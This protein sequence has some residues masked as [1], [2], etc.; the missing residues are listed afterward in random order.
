MGKRQGVFFFLERLAAMLAVLLLCAASA[1]SQESFPAKTVRVIVPWPPS[2]PPDMMSRLAAQ[3]LIERWGKP[4]IVENRPGATG[5]IG[6]DVV[7]KSAPDGH[8][9]LLTLNQPMVI[10][11]A[12]LRTPYDPVR[13]LLPIAMVGEGTNVLAVTPSLGVESVAELVA[14]AKAKPGALTFSSSGPGS[15]GHLCGELLKQLTGVDIVHV[16]YQGAA[17][18]TTAVITGEVSFG[19]MPVQ[20]VVPLV[21]AGKVKGLGVTSTRVSRFIPD[22]KPVS[23]QGL[24]GLVSVTWFAVYAPPKTPGPV[25]KVLRDG[26]RSAFEDPGIAQKLLAAGIEPRWEEAEQVTAVIESELAMW[27]RIVK[28]ARISKE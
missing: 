17:Q 3:K 22:L 19:F 21:K 14:A 12:L 28:A 4:V 7:A 26:M 16:P 2:G 20:Q 5:T 15:I 27:R 6:T 10:A 25:V 24:P 13:D 1:F 11:P 18:A 8:T 23:A 9:L